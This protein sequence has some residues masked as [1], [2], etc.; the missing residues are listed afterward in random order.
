[1]KELLDITCEQYIYWED[2][3]G[4]KRN[5][6][7]GIIEYIPSVLTEMKRIAKEWVL[8]QQKKGIAY[9]YFPW[10]FD[11]RRKENKGHLKRK[12]T[13]KEFENFYCH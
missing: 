11:G 10:L 3:H 1:M 9:L 6:E 5:E 4:R 12:T 7:C 13:L 8:Y 2:G